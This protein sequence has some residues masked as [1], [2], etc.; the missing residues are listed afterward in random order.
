MKFTLSWLKEHVETNASLDEI[1]D[2]LMGIGLEVEEVVDRTKDLAPFRVAKVKKAERH[3]NADRLS[4]C[5]VETAEGEIQVV[6]G[7][8][9]ARTG[10]TGIFVHP[11]THIPGT[12]INLERGLIRGVESNGMLVSERELMISDE[13]EGIIDLPNNFEVGTPAAVA[14][15][16]D[17]PMIYVKVTPNRPDALGVRGIA[18][19]LAAKGLGK[20][21]PLDVKPVAAT[22]K[23]PI[24]VELRFPDGDTRPCPLFIGRYFRGIENRS[25]PDWL[26]RR[27]TAIGLRPI[28]ALVDI[29]NY[30]TITY[31]RP[32][33]VFDADRLKGP[34]H[35]RL[36][37][38]GEEIFALDGRAY[39]LDQTMTA[40][41]DAA[42]P[43]GIGGIMGGEYSSC[44]PKTVNVFLE[45]AL[46]DPVRTA[47][48]GRKLGIISD[49]RYR[50]ER[51]VDPAFVETGAEI[52][53]RM[54]LELC[55]GEA[56]ELVVAGAPPEW[57][58]NSSLRKSRVKSL[59]GIDVPLPEQIRILTSLGFEVT[60]AADG[61]SCSVPSWR[62]D[63]QG[64][65]DLVEEV[66][67][68]V[69]LDKIPL[70]PL[71]RVH[72]VAAPVLSKLQKRMLLAR[73][74]LASRGMAEAVTWSFLPSA[75]AAL[76]SGGK[77]NP[78]LTLANPIS[79]ELTDMR[80]SLIPNLLSAASRNY[81]RGFD[82]IALFEVGQTYSGD[83]PQ[84]EKLRAAGLR[85][86]HNHERHWLERRRSIDPFD[87]K[88]DVLAVLEAC[89]APTKS[90]QV[91]QGGPD[92]L[93]PG[94]SGTIQ[95]GPKNQVAVFGEIHPSVLAA[96]DLK[97]PAVSFEVDLGAI[98]T[99]RSKSATRPALEASD[100][101][102]VS[103]DFAFVVDVDV[104]AERIL[105]AVRSADKALIS[106]ASIFDL[107]TGESLGAGKKSV[108]VNITL[109]P[110]AKTLTDQEIEAASQKIISEVVK[111]TGA[112][113]RS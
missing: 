41:A 53:S 73:R 3:P 32:L 75:H 66:C 44:T 35:A 11:G 33:H 95:L 27:L 17:D 85:R 36:A 81:A 55:G 46:F 109:Q 92:W 16:L 20:L 84:D 5:I 18:R 10:M 45:A 40:I 58:R 112:V 111:A 34:V 29:T 59:A 113:L 62:P 23:S 102:P 77:R 37:R 52:A 93:H 98:P 28:S 39:R 82:D 25:S 21:K 9:N 74:E 86:G 71:P 54:I 97:G 6:C 43:Q 106:D 57:R 94:R 38:A 50:F 2:A 69:G 100:L 99:P 15:G 13:H 80:P 67:R 1:L 61:L 60:E 78:A 49:A 88:A 7:A 83:R 51:G 72:A 14:L 89:G 4:V 19:D 24:A 26:K 47:A 108:A 79:S 22:F 65:A 96:F 68:I 63:I 48:T 87:A 90:L 56:S 107:F 30:I 64:E 70:A 12:G 31:N 91:I 101:M 110:R 103:R 105:K 104:E 42:G 76:F 8:P